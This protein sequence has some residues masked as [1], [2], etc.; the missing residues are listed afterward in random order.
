M[1]WKGAN[2]ELYAGG[3]V[4]R[5]MGAKGRLGEEVRR[6]QGGE[7]PREGWSGFLRGSM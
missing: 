7:G 1:C 5:C 3:E 4:T 2:G 6:I